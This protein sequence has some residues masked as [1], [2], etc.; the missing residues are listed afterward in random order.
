VRWILDKQGSGFALW[1]ARR[2]DQLDPVDAVYGWKLDETAMNE[3]D[4]I[5]KDHIK[6]PVGPEFMAP[7]ERA[8]A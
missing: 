1:G 4:R 3:I 7:P 6:Q 5:L 2:P 8:A